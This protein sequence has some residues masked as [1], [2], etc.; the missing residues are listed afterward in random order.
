MKFDLRQK[1]ISDDLVEMIFE[2]MEGDES[3]QI[4]GTAE[5]EKTTIRRNR[6]RQSVRRSMFLARKGFLMTRSTVR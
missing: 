2:D 6:T 3:A 5:K 4:L 1:G